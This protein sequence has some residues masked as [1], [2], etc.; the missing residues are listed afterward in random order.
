MCYLCVYLSVTLLIDKLRL[1]I[2]MALRDS[3]YQ[4]NKVPK[5]QIAG[6]GAS[7]SGTVKMVEGARRDTVIFWS[8][9]RP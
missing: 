5:Y 7:L 6:H 2:A 3:K 9:N 8:K 1:S 4:S